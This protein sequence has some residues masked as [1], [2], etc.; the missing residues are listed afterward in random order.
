V[1]HTFVSLIARIRFA[2]IPFSVCDSSFLFI[3]ITGPA[4]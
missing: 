4:T 2:G 3:F 1:Y